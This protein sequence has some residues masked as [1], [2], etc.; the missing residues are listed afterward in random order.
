MVAASCPV[1]HVGGMGKGLKKKGRGTELPLNCLPGL[2]G[3][4]RAHACT[5]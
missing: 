3:L 1:P 5:K 2:V 4:M